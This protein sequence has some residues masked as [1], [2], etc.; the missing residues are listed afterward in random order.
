M[1]YV[2]L[3]VTE[4]EWAEILFLNDCPRQLILHWGGKD[5]LQDRWSRVPK[6]CLH[7]NGSDHGIVID[8]ESMQHYFQV[9]RSRTFARASSH[10]GHRLNGTRAS[11]V[12]EPGKLS[13]KII[14]E[15]QSRRRS[16]LYFFRTQRERRSS[17]V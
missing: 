16:Q 10:G 12:F 5:N 13:A 4:S 2:S 6:S 3:L 9:R 7:G 15:N 11:A 8:N 1:C 14:A 17:V